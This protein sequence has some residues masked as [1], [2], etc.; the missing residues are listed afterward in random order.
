MVLSVNPGSVAVSSSDLACQPPIPLTGLHSQLHTLIQLGSSDPPLRVR[1]EPVDVCQFV[2]F[3][4]IAALQTFLVHLFRLLLHS[5]VT[6]PLHLL[7]R[8]SLPTHINPSTHT[9]LFPQVSSCAKCRISL[10]PTCA[11]MFLLI[12]LTYN[13]K[14]GVFCVHA[15]LV[16][17]F[18]RSDNNRIAASALVVLQLFLE[19]VFDAFHSQHSMDCLPHLSPFSPFG[20][21]FRQ[22]ERVW[23]E[24]AGREEL[25][26]IRPRKQSVVPALPF[27]IPVRL[28]H[29][30]PAGA[31]L[32]LDR[33]TVRLV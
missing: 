30:L 15:Q 25:T 16:V 8:S 20:V 23:V 26:K 13:K 18:D 28:P 1:T 33:R 24:D 22:F 3:H 6:T 31:S 7:H 9:S 11:E 21:P 2:G 29:N 19:D 12:H 4:S 5:F 27:L 32:L 17:P 10:P 14:C